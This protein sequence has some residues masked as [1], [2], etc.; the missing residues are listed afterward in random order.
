MPV[1]AGCRH[2]VPQDDRGATVRSLMLRRDVIEFALE[3]GKLYA[4][5]PVAGRT[6]GAVFVGHG[7]VSFAPPIALERR[8]VQRV[9]GASVLHF[10]ITASAFVFTEST[11]ATPGRPLSSGVGAAV[12]ES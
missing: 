10:R 7:S 4:V 3:E 8:E 11:W 6:I 9:L 2:M 5:T 1:F 12:A